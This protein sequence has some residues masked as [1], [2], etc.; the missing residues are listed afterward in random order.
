MIELRRRLGVR[1][2]ELR[3]EAGLTQEVLAESLG[4]HGSYVGLLERGTKSPSLETIGRIAEFFEV[5]VA[6]LFQT[7]A[8]S[9]DLDAR[10]ILRA[11]KRVQKCDLKRIYRI[12]EVLS[13]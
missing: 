3:R 11:L 5:E 12:L 4:C 13:E 8:D 1:I 7:E 6:D 2:L 9:K 10:R